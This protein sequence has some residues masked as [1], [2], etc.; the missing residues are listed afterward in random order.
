VDDGLGFAYMMM[1]LER[2]ALCVYHSF[3]IG[4]RLVQRHILDYQMQT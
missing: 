3:G 4:V 1:N 2:S